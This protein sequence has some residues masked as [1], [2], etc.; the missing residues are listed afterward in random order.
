MDVFNR[1][2][3][4]NIRADGWKEADHMDIEPH[5]IRSHRETRSTGELAL[6]PRS[7]T[8]CEP[9]LKDVPIIIAVYEGKERLL[10]GTARINLWVREKNTE[11]HDVYVHVIE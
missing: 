10:D 7:H 9:L 6:L 3:A 2:L 8:G 1:L 11:P 4:K 5:Q